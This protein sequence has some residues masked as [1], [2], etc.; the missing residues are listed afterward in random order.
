MLLLEW[1][2]DHK[3]A[4]DLHWSKNN[5]LSFSCCIKK[6]PDM[7]LKFNNLVISQD[8]IIRNLKKYRVE[9]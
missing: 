2:F 1:S 6:Q 3:N 8:T 4:N 9:L 5:A 7:N